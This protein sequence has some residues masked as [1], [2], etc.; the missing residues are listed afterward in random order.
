[1]MK[2]ESEGPCRCRHSIG[3]G[4]QSPRPR[5][6]L[7]TTPTTTWPLPQAPGGSV[8]PPR[9]WALISC[10]GTERPT[11]PRILRGPDRT[12]GRCHLG[13]TVDHAPSMACDW[14]TARKAQRLRSFYRTRCLLNKIVT[15]GACV[16]YISLYSLLLIDIEFYK[17]FSLLKTGKSKK[18]QTTRKTQNP[19][20]NPTVLSAEPE[21]YS[22]RC[23]RQGDKTG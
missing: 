3:E 21:R 11:G 23:R 19:K 17:S 13:G 5:V 15:K 2:S 16:W 4:A 14:S 12:R 10:P 6:G 1:M 8:H 9:R 20:P 22:C 18:K 7:W